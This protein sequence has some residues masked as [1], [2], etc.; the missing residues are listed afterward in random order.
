[1]WDFSDIYPDW[2][3]WSADMVKLER[4][5]DDYAAMQGTIG[6]DPEN[7]LKAFL[8]GD[9]LNKILYKV[10]R[11][12]GLQSDVDSRDNEMAA[13]F[14]EVRI[15]NSKFNVASSWFGPELLKIPWDKMESWLEKNEEL[16]PYRFGII[17][18]YR[19]QAHV[20]GEEEEQLLSYFGPFNGTP[21]SVYQ[22][23]TTSDIDYKDVV[24]ST[25]DT[26]R[27]TETQTF[28]TLRTSRVQADRA[29]IFEALYDV[30]NANINTYASIYN[31]VLQ[32]NWARAQARNY[33][34]C[35]EAALDGTNIPLSVYETLL[36]SVK[37]GTGPIKRYMKLR[38]EVLGL[39]SYH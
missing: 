26:I 28:A 33:N 37:N 15:I 31:G 23:I 36:A 13:K 12:A 8:L 4:L 27:A 19:S 29:K 18:L 35:L 34:S 3:T 22:E 1:K 10:W 17:D 5:M 9:E 25:G 7:L 16:A 6:E 39:D 32:G 21:S 24:L 11:Y 20:L 2:E 14:Q 38:K 30:F